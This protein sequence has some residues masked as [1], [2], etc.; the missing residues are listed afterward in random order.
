MPFFM[1]V[2]SLLWSSEYKELVSAHGFANNEI[3]I[4]RYPSMDKVA[5]LT[6]HTERVLHLALSSDGSTIVSIYTLVT[7]LRYL[8]VYGN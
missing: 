6:G 4:W 8:N 1:Q 7:N 5:E 2:C 3:I